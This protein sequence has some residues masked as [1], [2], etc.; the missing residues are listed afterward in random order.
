[1]KT[2]FND[3]KGRNILSKAEMQNVKGGGTCKALIPMPQ[4]ATNIDGYFNKNN[5]FVQAR[6]SIEEAK[7]TA[8]QYGGR[9]CC[10]SCDNASWT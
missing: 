7:A 3:L 2:T 4:T 1:M 10:D 5:D 6:L 9:W 8:T